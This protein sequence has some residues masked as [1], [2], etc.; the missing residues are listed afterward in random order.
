M[1]KG[2]GD[3]KGWIT[4]NG[5]HIPIYGQYTVRGGVEP[6][7]KG[8]RWK[9]KKRPEN[10]KEGLKQ[11][12][13]I[14]KIAEEQNRKVWNGGASNQELYDAADKFAEEKNFNKDKV[15]DAAFSAFNEKWWATKKEKEA[16]QN[17]ITDKDGNKIAVGED[18]RDANLKRLREKNANNPD[19]QARKA[20]R[21]E[22][23]NPEWLQAKE[24]FDSAYEKQKGNIE[25]NR[26]EAKQQ[27]RQKANEANS[28][29]NEGMDKDQARKAVS[30][31][32]EEGKKPVTKAEG[33]KPTSFQEQVND[34][35]KTK[36]EWDEIAKNAGYKD[37][38]DPEFQKNADDIVAKNKQASSSKYDKV[39]PGGASEWSGITDRGV[40]EAVQNGNKAGIEE[41]SRRGLSTLKDYQ[42]FKN[43]Q[44]GSKPD[45]RD[46]TKSLGD[47]GKVT[48]RIK[49][50]E[51]AYVDD[52]F[53]PQVSEKERKMQELRDAERAY[54]NEAFKGS[55]KQEN[56][57]PDFSKMSYSEAGKYVS[58]H[59][60]DFG[61]KPGDDAYQAAYEMKQGTWK[62]PKEEKKTVSSTESYP[63]TKSFGSSE[64]SATEYGKAMESIG[65]RYDS[66]N[67]TVPGKEMGKVFE[68]LKPGDQIQVHN[69]Y[70][71]SPDRYIVNDDGTIDYSTPSSS[72]LGK[73]G[74][75]LAEAQK[76]ATNSV[77]NR[78][79]VMRRKTEE[80]SS[81]AR[82]VSGNLVA[83]GS[84]TTNTRN[85]SVRNASAKQNKALNDRIYNQSGQQSK[86]AFAAR[87]GNFSSMSVSGLKQAYA[88][89]SGSEKSKIR[90]ELRKKGYTYVGGKWVKGKKE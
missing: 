85:T 24:K 38:S 63:G 88:N 89:A 86:D 6:K 79:T 73:K 13:G 49:S 72:F 27:A 65:K 8:A 58:K 17:Y 22:K 57:T 70:S 12:E 47:G 77:D 48:S 39:S 64:P 46:E 78:I 23:E 5:V 1:A 69:K 25:A 44:A 55:T 60:K 41:M 90:A 54:V 30:E 66:E 29:V 83:G 18:A 87:K 75:S 14:Q 26:E 76:H 34:R 32:T 71:V 11:H 15:R 36:R 33:K 53:K 62:Q 43:E 28:L 2:K 37:S 35:F 20:E 9:R 42:N 68:G 56:S 19:V 80:G 81:V 51:Q 3:I 31:Q 40:M 52:A 67:R 84:D 10:F 82:K 21:A 16:G 74:M 45:M 59:K 7:A 4:K 61:L 50:R